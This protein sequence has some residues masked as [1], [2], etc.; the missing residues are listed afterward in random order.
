MLNTRPGNPLT[1]EEAVLVRGAVA[2]KGV[3]GASEGVGC[4]NS[5]LAPP[6]ATGP[7]PDDT[8]PLENVPVPDGVEVTPSI[9]T[10]PFLSKEGDFWIPLLTPTHSRPPLSPPPGRPGR[11]LVEEG[12]GEEDEVEE[13]EE[14][15]EGR[16]S[17]AVWCS[18]PSVALPSG[19]LKQGPYR[20][21]QFPLFFFTPSSPPSPILGPEEEP[22]EEEEDDEGRL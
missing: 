2:V 8:S 14:D 22:A 17:G 4:C 9:C 1:W 21:L 16:G 10:L 3:G 15:D 6:I 12:E 11:A 20:F 13:R 5:A 19:T 7:A 18:G